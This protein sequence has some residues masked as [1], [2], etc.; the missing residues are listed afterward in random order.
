MTEQDEYI[1]QLLYKQISGIALTAAETSALNNWVNR[2]G[3][4]RQVLDEIADPQQFQQTL[5]RVY[6]TDKDRLWEKVNR[7]RETK[8]AIIKKLFRYAAAVILLV[9]AGT[10]FWYHQRSS[11]PVVIQQPKEI[12]P[13][14]NKA[15]LTLA[16]GST[17]TLDSNG[18]QVIAQGNT[19]VRQQN[20][21]LTYVA[22]ANN[23]HTET[24]NT[25][26][27]P[28]GGQFKVTLPDG[29]Q[30]WLNAASSLRYP[31]V[32]TGKE[33]TVTLQ[34]EAYFEVAENARQPFVVI[35]SD[36]TVKA[37]GTAFNINA[38]KDEET[39]NTTL[40]EGKVQVQ[41]AILKPGEQAVLTQDAQLSINDRADVNAV[42][43]WKEGQ[44]YFNRTPLPVILRQFA[45]W[46]NVEVV[47]EGDVKPRTFYGVI[48]RQAPLS[49]VLRMLQA[50]DIQFRIDGNKL[51]VT[52]N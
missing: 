34:G 7:H 39:I 31:T 19:A 36:M 10:W 30:V 35:A 28:R 27:T 9:S 45:R 24:F 16:D 43:A 29:S 12:L 6:E 17:V 11:P 37:L 23:T 13:G 33:R 52:S 25:L 50:N 22:G 8:P 38:Y 40:L 18:K 20:G 51:I 47:Y 26:T 14:S 49:T 32:F 15:T 21:Q 48:S 46:Y 5:A 4:N 1:V 44:F 2:S 41:S 42:I 3:H